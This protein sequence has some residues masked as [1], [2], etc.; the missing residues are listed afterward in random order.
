MFVG[1]NALHCAEVNAAT[2]DHRL[3]RG[4]DIDLQGRLSV[5]F[6]GHI[7]HVAAV[8]QAVGRGVCPSAGHINAH[9]RASPHDLVHVGVHARQAFVLLGRFGQCFAQQGES[10]VRL[11]GRTLGG[12]FAAVVAQH[13]RAEHRIVYLRHQR[14]FLRERCGQVKARLGKTLGHVLQVRLVEHAAL[15]VGGQ[16]LDV[17]FLEGFA[18]FPRTRQIGL[19]RNFVGRE[20]RQAFPQGRQVLR[21]RGRDEP[22]QQSFHLLEVLA[23]GEETCGLQVVGAAEQGGINVARLEPFVHGLAQ[24]K[25]GGI[26]HVAAESICITVRSQGKSRTA[27]GHDV[28]ANTIGQCDVPVVAG[29]ARN[30]IVCRVVPPLAEV[31]IFNPDMRIVFVGTMVDEAVLR[32][33]RRLS[34]NASLEDIALVLH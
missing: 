27:D 2:N 20:A 19:C 6:D 25:G 30:N 18:L 34:F 16:C 1:L 28:Q 9:R 26:L 12:L 17:F 10:L 33:D 31:G 3:G 24:E 14:R 13:F 22:V 7:D 8:E 23:D 15:P 5:H 11:C 21:R 4:L 32:E 29:H